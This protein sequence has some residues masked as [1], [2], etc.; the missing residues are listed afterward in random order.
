MRL[1]ECQKESV[2]KLTRENVKKIIYN[3]LYKVLEIKEDDLTPSEAL[4]ITNFINDEID[5]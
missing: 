5:G 4:E 2:E 1:F 3:F